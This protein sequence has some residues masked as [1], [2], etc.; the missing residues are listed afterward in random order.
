MSSKWQ[1][2]ALSTSF[3]ENVRS[4]IPLRSTQ[5]EVIL[6][7]IKLWNPDVKK[8]MDLGCGD[9]ILGRCLLEKYPSIELFSL[10]FSDTMLDAARNN[11][12]HADSVKFF[13]ADFSTLLWQETTSTLGKLD[14]VISGFAIHHLS[15]QRKKEVY[16]EINDLLNP[17]GLFLN[18]EHVSSTTQEVETV[19]DDCFVDSLHS[20]HLKTNAQA[21]RETIADNYYNRPDKIENILAP[22]DVQCEWLREIGY[23]DVD[24][25][26]K[27]F[28]LALFG[29][30]KAMT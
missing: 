3:L 1:T 18:L 29:G 12:G 21:K 23:Q 4:A 9:G 7:L 30:R 2:E 27:F 28:E 16:Q 22:V 8:V 13:K 14:L 15:D 17:G 5:I 11:L 6:K 25:Y 19:F 24:C 10:D 26:F 20:Y